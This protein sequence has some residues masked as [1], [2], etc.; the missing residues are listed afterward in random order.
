[1][2]LGG[3]ILLALIVAVVV[4]GMKVRKNSEQLLELDELLQGSSEE[5]DQAA[6]SNKS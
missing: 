4:I 5:Q 6:L 2:T 3:F 1:M